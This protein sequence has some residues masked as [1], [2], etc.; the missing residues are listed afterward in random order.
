MQNG[1]ISDAK[2]IQGATCRQ[3]GLAEVEPEAMVAIALETLGKSPVYGE[4]VV[5]APGAHSGSRPRMRIENAMHSS[6]SSMQ[7][8]VLA[9][10]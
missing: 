1:E 3:Y 7:R 6:Y 10:A 5:L 9:S 4:R 8:N 2:N